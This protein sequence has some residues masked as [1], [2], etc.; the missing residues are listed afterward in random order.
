MQ[1]WVCNSRSISDSLGTNICG[2]EVAKCEAV[3]T[4]STVSGSELRLGA[5]AVRRDASRLLQAMRVKWAV[6]VVQSRRSVREISGGNWGS[7]CEIFSCRGGDWRSLF[8]RCDAILRG[9]HLPTILRNVGKCQLDN[10]A[11]FPGMMVI[12]F[13]LC[14]RLV[15]RFL[16]IRLAAMN[17]IRINAPL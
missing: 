12:Y 16:L 14:P 15:I 10:T 2:S 5:R 7:A 1:E 8:L 4:V 11:P 9:T 3:S 17:C 13:H 6:T